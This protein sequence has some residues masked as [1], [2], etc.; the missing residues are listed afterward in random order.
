M[1]FFK[2]SSNIQKLILY[3][4][5]IITLFSDFIIVFIM[6]ITASNALEMQ[7]NFYEAIFLIIIVSSIIMSVALI[8]H[9]IFGLG[10]SNKYSNTLNQ[11]N[12][13]HD[14]DNHIE[15]QEHYDDNS[16]N[17]SNEENKHDT[18]KRPQ[19]HQ[20]HSS[21]QNHRK[22]NNIYHERNRSQPTKEKTNEN[23]QIFEDLNKHDEEDYF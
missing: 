7:N 5:S 15:R 3:S 4:F 11:H 8:I 18:I 6:Y 12:D 9:F 2:N 22:N 1:N 10:T 16:F 23:D 19:S 20:N 14:H 17:D 21:N 13:Y